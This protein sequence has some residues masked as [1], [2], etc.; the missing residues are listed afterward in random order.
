MCGLAGGYMLIVIMQLNCM[1]TALPGR[2]PIQ[3]QYIQTPA[4]PP[5]VQARAQEIPRTFS[6]D[7][8][9]EQLALWLSQL[10]G[11]DYHEDID[12]LKGTVFMFTHCY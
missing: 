2:R 4:Q 11:T 12:K 6:K 7:L 3:Q 8:S 9:S 1:Y 10:V 5:Q